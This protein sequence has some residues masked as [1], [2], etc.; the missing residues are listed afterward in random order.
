M[1]HFWKMCFLSLVVSSFTITLILYQSYRNIFML[2][3]EYEQQDELVLPQHDENNSTSFNGSDVIIVG[4]GRSGTTF[5]GELFD[6]HPDVF[7]VFEPLIFT[8]KRL[9]LN[10]FYE[11]ETLEYRPEI[12]STLAR[13]LSCNF[14]GSEDTIGQLFNSPF[15]YQSNV[16]K[17]IV[18]DGAKK[19]VIE[20][21]RNI[22][23][24]CQRYKHRVVKILSGRLS[25]VSIE[26]L[27]DVVDVSLSRQRQVKIIHLVRDPRAVAHSWISNFWIKGSNDSHFRRNIKRM[28]EPMEKNLRLGADPPRWLMN[29]YK[30]IRYKKLVTNAM[31]TAEDI[32]KFVGIKMARDVKLW[33]DS[34]NRIPSKGE[35]KYSHSTVRVVNSTINGW[36][37]KLSNYTKTLIE[38]A[39]S[40]VLKRLHLG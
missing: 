27:R 39:C 25:N 19:S 31:E 23:R 28:C 15:R 8:A 33:V 38:E 4:Q 16:L 37:V 24:V 7:Y 34:R 40:N 22:S 5:M 13:F 2:L 36:K 14:T 20:L 21:S 30:L 11:N 29:R 6:S 17:K 10:I 35:L 1:R 18:L 26:T 3:V 12:T 9:N 32:F